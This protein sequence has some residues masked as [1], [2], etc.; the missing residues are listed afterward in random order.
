MSV[1]LHALYYSVV[2]TQHGACGCSGKSLGQL[3]TIGIEYDCMAYCVVE[4][5]CGIA[6]GASPAS[7]KQCARQ[8]LA[9]VQDLFLLL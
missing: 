9:F 3:H 6:V 7:K 2:L 1:W 5:K 8:R 4:M